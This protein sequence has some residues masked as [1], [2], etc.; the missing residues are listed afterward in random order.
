MVVAVVVVVLVVVVDG[1]ENGSGDVT[2]AVWYFGLLKVRIVD[3]TKI[4]R[5]EIEFNSFLTFFL[6]LWFLEQSP[7]KESFMFIPIDRFQ[8]QVENFVRLG[9]GIFDFEGRR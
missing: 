2:K 5:S 8:F 4:G 3:D 9:F 6:L 1:S 7:R